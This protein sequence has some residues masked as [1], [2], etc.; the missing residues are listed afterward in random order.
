MR[1]NVSK[2]SKSICDIKYNEH[3]TRTEFL[4]IDNWYLI[5]LVKGLVPDCVILG[6][7]L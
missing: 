3:C 2:N 6:K 5:K 1:E 4:W 7:F